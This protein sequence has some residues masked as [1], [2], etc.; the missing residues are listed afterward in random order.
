[1]AAMAYGKGSHGRIKVRSIKLANPVRQGVA[2]DRA[3]AASGSR[4]LAA[5][6]LGGN[7]PRREGV[8]SFVDFLLGRGTQH[9]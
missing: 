5:L 3:N 8:S 9:H 7:S 6:T 2:A 1:M 4:Q